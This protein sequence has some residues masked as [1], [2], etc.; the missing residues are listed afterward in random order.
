M[1]LLSLHLERYG[2]FTDRTLTFRPD[3]RLH[4]VLGANEAGKSTALAAVTDLLFGFGKSTAYAFRHDMPLL[5]IGAEI[6]ASDGRRLA[7]RRRKGN[8]RTLIDGQD[9][10]LPDDALAPFLGGLSRP[11]SFGLDAE[12]LRQGGKEMVD[13]EGEV[14]ASLFAAGSGLRGLTELQS[15]LDGE[16][17]AIFTT[18]KAGHRTFYQAL[19]RWQEFRKAERETG[20]STV[21][22]RQ[23]NEGTVNS[24]SSGAFTDMGHAPSFSDNLV[25][26]ARAN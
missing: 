26:V 12:A 21:D 13:V 23:L 11:V 19:D 10:P 17:E 6:A 8:A 2:A 25:E 5:R 20:I 22:W 4:V 16:A 18:R 15:R 24:I 9:A 7:F 14:G 1:R 3:A